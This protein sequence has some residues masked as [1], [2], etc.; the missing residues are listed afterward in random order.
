MATYSLR[1]SNSPNAEG[2]YVAEVYRDDTFMCVRLDPDRAAVQ[3]KAE[4][5]V[6][7]DRDIEYELIDLTDAPDP[8]DFT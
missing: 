2:W 3:L 8:R 5:W 6:A 7:D 4:R 1:V